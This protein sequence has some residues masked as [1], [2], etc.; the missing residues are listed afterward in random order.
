[1]NTTVKT[2]K[3]NRVLMTIAFL[4]VSLCSSAQGSWSWSDCV[5]WLRNYGVDYLAGYARPMYAA[6]GY[7]YKVIQNSNDAV[8]EITYEPLTFL[9]SRTLCRYKVIRG[10]Y[11]GRSY[12]YNV[13]VMRDPLLGEPFNSWNAVQQY[14]YAYENLD[15]VYN[16]FDGEMSFSNLPL[17]K[18]AAAALSLEFFSYLANK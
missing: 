6:K 10:S 5:D 1:M 7:D 4:F 13:E 18:K 17:R 11:N 2:G 12:F 8:V 14:D 9:G 16:L 3:L 15:F